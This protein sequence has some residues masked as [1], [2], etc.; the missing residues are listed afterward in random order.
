M[1]TGELVPRKAR[2]APRRLRQ[3]LRRALQL[4]MSP[5]D[6]PPACPTG[7]GQP[8]LLLHGFASSP[9]ALGPLERGLRATTGRPVLRV[10]IS[11]SLDDLRDS[12]ERVEAVLDEFARCCRFDYVDVVG[13][14]MGGLVASYLLKRIDRGRRIRRVV[15]LGTPHRGAASAAIGGRVPEHSTRLTALPGHRNLRVDGA[16][17]WGLLF[18]RPGLELVG[19]SL[20]D[21]IDDGYC[22]AA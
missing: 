12:A 7:A 15:T 10:A 14:S 20:T 3:H 21:A 2:R 16:S 18:S 9:R 5:H 11:P 6:P 4:V 19:A 13:H 8:I 17:H 1:S 22:L